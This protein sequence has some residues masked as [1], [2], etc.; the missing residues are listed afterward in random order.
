MRVKPPPGSIRL[1][2]RVLAAIGLLHCSRAEAGHALRAGGY[3][4]AMPSSMTARL[5][6]GNGSRRLMEY[7]LQNRL[8]LRWDPS[9]GLAFH[10]QMRWRLFAGDTI[11]EIPG[12]AD[13]IGQDAGFFDLSWMVAETDDWLLHYIPDRLFGEWD[14]AGWNLRAGRQ[15]VNWGVNM[16]TNPND[17][18]NIYSIYDFDYPERP[19]ADAVRFQRFLDF[20]SRVELAASPARKFEEGIAAALY[21]FHAEGHDL[22]I[23]GGYYRERLAAGAGWA[24]DLAGAGLKAEAMGFSDAQRKSNERESTVIAALSADYMFPNRLFL[25]IELLYNQAGGMTEFPAP[26]ARLRPDNPSFS[27]YQVSALATYPA[28]PL[29]DAGL[30]T[31]FYPDEKAAFISPSVTW[32][33]AEDLDFKTLGQF[34][35]NRGDSVFSNAADLLAASLTY[36]F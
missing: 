11:R 18:F 12:Y 7:R 29:V 5:P 26:D 13:G 21:A 19:G 4:E 36:H 6:D 3:I 25:I 32:S 28:H 23:I 10:W 33:M 22:Q 17:I 15:R 2:A 1:S 35:L 9:P 16:I 27:K 30:T 20:G 34:F 14:A 8:N 31:I 24:C